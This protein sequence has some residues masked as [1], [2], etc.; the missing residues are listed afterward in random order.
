IQ[1]DYSDGNLYSYYT[2][3]GVST[4][5]EEP[6][7]T[8]KG[9]KS[10][11]DSGRA[12]YG[13]AG[14]TPDVAMKPQTI[15]I[16]T[17]RFQAKLAN[18]IFGFALDLSQGKVKGFET[19]KID[20][21]IAFDYDLKPADYAVTDTIFQAFKVYAA[22]KYKYAPA[23]ID[24]EREFVER[25]LRSEL[26]TAAYGSTTSFQVFNEYDNQLLKAIEL[27]PQAKQLAM[28][29]AKSRANAGR[30]DAMNK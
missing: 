6:V 3:G 19:L 25:L 8:P 4:D 13:G 17:A 26:V 10:L 18:P 5:G 12:V 9:P 14:I 15:P 28:E 27:L 20:K 7:V 11:T 29:G 30:R 24:K 22:Q 1:R 2:K 23:Q 16:E 21:P